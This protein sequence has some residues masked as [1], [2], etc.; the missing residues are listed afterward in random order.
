MRTNS[1]WPGLNAPFL[2]AVTI[3]T[4]IA[5]LAACGKPAAPETQTHRLFTLGTLVDITLPKATQVNNSETSST[6]SHQQIDRA[7]LAV[8]QALNRTHTKWHGW[9]SGALH[10]INLALAQ[11]QA[12][13]LD[14]EQL[15]LIKQAIK[16]SMQSEQLFNPAIGKLVALWGFHDDDF[17]G[18]VPPGNEKILALLASSPSMQ[19]LDINNNML[20]SRNPEVQIDVGAFAKGLAIDQAIAILQQ[21]GIQHAIVNAGGDLR[22]I[23]KNNNRAWRIGIRHPS[24]SGIIASI[25][26]QSGESIFT[27]GSYERYFEYQGQRYHHIIDP[28]TGRPATGALSVTVI[29]PNAGIADAAA[30]ALIIAGPEHWQDIA[31]KMGIN[32]VM[33]VDSQ[34]NVHLSPA[35]AARIQFETTPPPT[36]ITHESS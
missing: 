20:S 21:H 3:L 16:L 18:K 26:A 14:D 4:L 11:G 8:E 2:A 32:Y 10:D 9:Q 13:K 6:A 28:R 5:T 23:G 31:Q 1:I 35:M 29:H 22:V 27:S 17:Q 30:T 25:E 12:I 36:I 33:L 34:M 7:I 19:Q 15:T 24:G